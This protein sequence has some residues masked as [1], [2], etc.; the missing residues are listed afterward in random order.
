MCKVSYWYVKRCLGQRVHGW[1]I[2]I[3]IIIIII[4]ITRRSFRPKSGKTLIKT[5]FFERIVKVFPVCNLFQNS[6]KLILDKNFSFEYVS[7][8]K[9]DVAL[10]WDNDFTTE[11]VC[12]HSMILIPLKSDVKWWFFL[13]SYRFWDISKKTQFWSLKRVFGP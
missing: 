9:Y 10:Y 4:R 2:I 13:I 1:I 7:D 11:V 3:I 6:E 12:M 8:V 5:Q